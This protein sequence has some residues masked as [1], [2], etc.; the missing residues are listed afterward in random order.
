MKVQII[1]IGKMSKDM[2]TICTKYQKMLSWAVK[3]IELPHSKKG[4]V[5]EIKA[6]ETKAIVAKL[7]GNALVVI[8]DRL[9]KQF[10]SEEF[11]DL[12]SQQM[13]VGGNIDFVIGGAYGLDELIYKAK[14]VRLC[15]SKMTFPHQIAKIL[16]LE[17]L[18]RA[19]TIIQNHPYHK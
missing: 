16:L 7:R 5:T 17:Q 4:S 12:I 2:D 11:S 9:G 1:A 19:Q 18:Y 13:M 15:L 8:L 6:E 10:S 14:N 3:T